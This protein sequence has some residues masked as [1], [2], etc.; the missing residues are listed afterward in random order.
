MLLALG[1]QSPYSL[2]WSIIPEKCSAEKLVLLRPDHNLDVVGIPNRCKSFP[3]NVH[4]PQSILVTNR[5]LLESTA[6]NLL[7]LKLESHN[8]FRDLRH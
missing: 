4:R 6:V 5:D 7:G 1:D 2:N 8:N 3:W